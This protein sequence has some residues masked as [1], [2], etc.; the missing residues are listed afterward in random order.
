MIES[1]LL[2]L[3]VCIDA[4][5]ASIAYG[6]NKIEIPILSS[7]I[8]SSIGSLFLGVSI[9]AGGFIKDFLPGSLPTLLSF[10]ILMILGIYRLFE[11]LFKNYIQ[12]KNALDKPLKFKIF[13]INFVLQVYADE[14][15]ADFDK[16]KILT[17]K[18]SLYL[19]SALSFD[20]LAVGFG[21]SLAGGGYIRTIILCFIIGIIIVLLGVF[22]GKKLLEKSNINLSWLSGVILMILAINKLF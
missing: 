10:S 12:Q 7:I 22:I 17:A 13:D 6:T 18:E 9:F 1:L 2:V 4:F 21:S 11:G 5:V 16:S 19:A 8:I 3:S 20:S 14:T 15:K